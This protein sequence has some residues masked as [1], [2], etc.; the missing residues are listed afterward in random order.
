MMSIEMSKMVLR[1]SD[2]GVRV[3]LKLVKLDWYSSRRVFLGALAGFWDGSSGVSGT[4]TADEYSVRR[5]FDA[6]N[7]VL[8]VAV[9]LAGG[10]KKVLR[11]FS[12][13]VSLARVALSDSS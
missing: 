11:R 9:E 4:S 7:G 2:I 12:T 6:P 10:L 1:R 5:L 8:S 3:E 13:G